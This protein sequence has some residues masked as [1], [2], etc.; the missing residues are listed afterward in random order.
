MNNIREGYKMTV[1]GEIPEAWSVVVLGECS[2]I[3]KLAGFEFTEYME[4][5]DDGEIIHHLYII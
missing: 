5:I 4:Y 3:T 2:N 1:F